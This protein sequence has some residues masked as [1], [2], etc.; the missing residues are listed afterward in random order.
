MLSTTE[1]LAAQ[2]AHFAVLCISNESQRSDVSR[3]LVQYA[4]AWIDGW[5]AL[6]VPPALFLARTARAVG[7]DAFAVYLQHVMMVLEQVMMSPGALLVFFFGIRMLPE[8]LN[9]FNCR[10]PDHGDGG[11]RGKLDDIVS[12]GVLFLS[13]L[14]LQSAVAPGGG[15][16]TGVGGVPGMAVVKP[17]LGLG[18]D[19]A[20]QQQ[21]QPLP[22]QNPEAVAAGKIA[23]RQVYAAD[24]IPLAQQEANLSNTAD[25]SATAVV[26]PVAVA[27]HRSSA[28]GYPQDYSVSSM[29]TGVACSWVG[30]CAAS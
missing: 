11:G 30:C 8:Y 4:A 9:H 10:A 5:S 21:P 23:S 29:C 20:E 22:N 24:R 7:R 27:V 15:G 2:L 13:D 18:L 19:A 16:S 25:T 14:G 1:F 17:A 3:V 6:A 28:V 12:T 26:Y